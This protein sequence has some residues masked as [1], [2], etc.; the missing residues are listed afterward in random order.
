MSTDGPT[1]HP[2]RHL[3]RTN[4]SDHGASAPHRIIGFTRRRGK[5]ERALGPREL[6]R[7]IQAMVPG[8]YRRLAGLAAISFTGGL[9]EAGLIVLL[10][11]VAVAATEDPQELELLPWIDVTVTI[12]VAVL[13]LLLLL[14]GKVLTGILIARG[15]AAMATSALTEVRLRLLGSF[16]GASWPVQATERQGHLQELM[17]THADRVT[18]VN[19]AL[20]TFVTASLN[21]A[22]LVVIAL[23]VDPVAAIAIVV[24]GAMLSLSLR[25]L[26]ALVRRNAARH[27]AAGERFA[28]AVAEV[29][30]TARELHIF[31]TSNRVFSNLEALHARQAQPYRRSRFLQA[32]GPQLYQAA[33]LLVLIL[34]LGLVSTTGSSNLAA[35]GAVVLLLL[36]ALGYGQ[37]S[38][39]A[40]QTLND[41]VPYLDR[42]RRQRD[43]YLANQAQDG[44]TPVASL[45]RLELDNVRYEYIP[46]RPVLRGVSGTIDRGEAV[47]IIGPSGSGKSTLLQIILRLREPTYGRLLANGIDA[48]YLELPGWYARVAFVPQDPQLIEGTVAENIAFYRDIPDGQ[49]RRA[50]EMANLAE[51][52]ALLP[53]GYDELIGP[54]DTAL[55]G[56]QQQRLTIAR[57]L[58]AKP[59]LLVLDE[60]TSALD[61][62][63]EARIQQTLRAIHGQVTL[64]VVAHRLSTIAEC[65]RVMVLTDGV[66]QGFDGHEALLAS[67]GFYEETLQLSVL[68]H[69]PTGDPI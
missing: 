23:V 40:F 41:T 30:S 39:A 49:I 46:D 60:P 61:M 24:L 45:G 18:R 12:P 54:E 4:Q 33:A 56:G 7:R 15:S 43:V 35:I 59:D 28:S 52:I 16:L 2:P 50:A 32:L 31:G 65:D 58:A 42:V 47:G 11:R 22:I 10:A 36:R 25:P 69:A 19:F 57:A 3:R 37:Q 14:A 13:V 1:A 38:Q 48:R 55:S 62:R 20:A 51:E 21:M 66:V 68:Q 8:S 34:G 29:V 9:V 26:A 63:S 6:A 44:E 5:G 27:V 17:T 67:S 53:S 64:L